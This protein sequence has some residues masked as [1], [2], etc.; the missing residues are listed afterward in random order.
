MNPDLALAI[1]VVLALLLIVG[2][3]LLKKYEPK[4][5]P[6]V[7]KGTSTTKGTLIPSQHAESGQH[8]HIATPSHGT[9]SDKNVKH[10]SQ[11]VH[12]TKLPK[13]KVQAFCDGNFQKIL[14]S[15][16]KMNYKT[17]CS[18]PTNQLAQMASAMST[19]EGFVLMAGAAAGA[20]GAAAGATGAAAG[21]TGAA[22][23]GPMLIPAMEF[24][25]GMIKN[26]VCN[27]GL[28]VNTR[29]ELETAVEHFTKTLCNKAVKGLYKAGATAVHGLQHGTHAVLHG[30]EHGAHDV[31]HFVHQLF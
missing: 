21:A 3:L 8:T 11:V 18:S 15:F 7:I 14:K 26:M 16:L 28:T 27:G 1:I 30:L 22:A 19:S 9:N 4:S 31:K 12:H 6:I 10:I 13:D 24:A 17:L 5:H 2:S 25:L 23:L 20:T 29:E